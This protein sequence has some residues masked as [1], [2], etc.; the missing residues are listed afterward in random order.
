MQ[1]NDATLTFPKLRS[2]S[3]P[4]LNRIRGVFHR[5]ILLR[6]SR[7]YCYWKGIIVEQ[8]TYEL[9]FNLIMKMTHKVREEEV[10]AME[11]ARTIGIPTPRVYSYGFGTKKMPFDTIV[12]SRIPGK[13]L[14]EVRKSLSP[15]ELDTIRAELAGYVELMRQYKSPWGSRICS[16]DNTA[17]RGARIPGGLMD[18]CKDE[19]EF[20]ERFIRIGSPNYWDWPEPFEEAVSKAKSMIEVQHPI[21]F[22]HG[23]LQDHNIMVHNGHISGIIDW[24]YAGWFP[25]YWE[26][27]QMFRALSQEWWWP[28]F[29]RKLPGY[30]YE[31]EYECYDVAWRLAENS[32]SW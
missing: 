21:V 26:Y 29:C 22:T 15:A 3:P 23:D 8:G 18:P 17:V 12:M 14:E 19:V 5:K 1:P 28:Q 30:K 9:P 31:R 24:E 7:W 11:V 10:M 20:I 13:T 6:V 2:R 25:D 16:V 32:F 4:F 27:T